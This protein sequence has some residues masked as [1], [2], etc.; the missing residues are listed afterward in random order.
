V[1]QADLVV[2]GQGDGRLGGGV[3]A[4]DHDD[5]LVMV[6]A[7]VEQ[8]GVDAVA[9]LAG[10]A[11]LA[12]IAHPAHGQDHAARSKDL[13]ALGGHGEAVTA[14]AHVVDIDAALDIDPGDGALPVGQQF[15]LGGVVEVE[16]AESLHARRLGVDELAGGEVEDGVQG[17]AL[18]QQEEAVAAA[19]RLQGGRQAGRTGTD[20]DQIVEILATPR[21]RWRRACRRIRRIRG[22]RGHQARDGAHHFDALVDAGLQQR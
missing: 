6:L 4:P 5:A 10:Y 13:A 18:F 15:F 16:G 21:R 22:I 19:P 9:L 20:D 7:R 3:A 12:R 2:V 11:E 1:D 8:G 17:T 14:L